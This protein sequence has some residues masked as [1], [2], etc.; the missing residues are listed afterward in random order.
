LDSQQI[1]ATR[2]EQIQT[3]AD[4]TQYQIDN[5]QFMALPNDHYVLQLTAVS[6]QAVLAEYLSSAPVPVDTLRIYQVRRNGTDWIVVTY[7]LFESIE[8]ARNEAKRVAPKAWAKSISVIQQQIS[9]YQNTI[10]NP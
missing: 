6:S 10:E 4:G 3:L 1:I 5:Q 2:D 8:Q 7:G 9:A